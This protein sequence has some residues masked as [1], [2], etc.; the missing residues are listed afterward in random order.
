MGRKA[1]QDIQAQTGRRDDVDCTCDRSHGVVAEAQPLVEAGAEPGV[2]TDRLDESKA[3][4][5]TVTQQCGF[6]VR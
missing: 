4:P 6:Q 5:Q 3:W 1:E 2:E